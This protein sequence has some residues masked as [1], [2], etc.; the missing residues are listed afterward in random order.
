MYNNLMD[1][2]SHFLK[3][4]KDKR[5]EKLNIVIDLEIIKAAFKYIHIR[6]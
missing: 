5:S 3:S 4:V 6:V 1:F 2:I